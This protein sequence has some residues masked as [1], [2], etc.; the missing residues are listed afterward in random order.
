[1]CAQI[2]LGQWTE[3]DINILLSTAA[4]LDDVCERI[5][6]ISGK[7]LETPYLEST[8]IGGAA[9]D[10]ELVVNLSGIDCFTF[11]DYVESMRRA[12]SFEGFLARLKETRYRSGFV[13]YKNRNHFFTDWRDSNKPFII[14]ATR[15][16]GLEKTSQ[17][18]KSLNLKSDGTLFLEGIPIRSRTVDFIPSAMIGTGVLDLL[19][20]G[21]YVGIYSELDGLD[22]S[23]VGIAIRHDDALYFRHASSAQ[24]YR[25]VTDQLLVNYTKEKPGIVVLRPREIRFEIFHGKM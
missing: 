3:E 24:L 9:V 2:S 4:R 20:T 15:E 18:S 11:L 7:F 13:D 5:Q 17:C 8:L 12:S 16:V 14:D 21:D 23:H 25:K 6:Y 19:R 22:V 1:M 10:E